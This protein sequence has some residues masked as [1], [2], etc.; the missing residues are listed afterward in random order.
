LAAFHRA[1]H[2]RYSLGPPAL[3]KEKL[4][5]LHRYPTYVVRCQGCGAWYRN[6]ALTALGARRG[7]EADPYGPG[8]LELLRRRYRRQY[9]GAVG[10]LRRW[11]PKG[12]RVLE[13]GSYAAAFLEAGRAAGWEVEGVDVGRDVVRYARDL[14]LTVHL[15]DVRDLDLP[16]EDYDAVFVWHC[17]EQVPEHY[18]FLLRLRDLLRPGGLLVLRTPNAVYYGAALGRVRD[19]P[20]AERRRL[21]EHLAFNGLLPFPFARAYPPEGL[22]LL[23]TACGFVDPRSTGSASGAGT[24]PTYRPWARV[25][26][27]LLDRWAARRL[28]A[29]VPQG[30]A[31]PWL[32]VTARRG[33][34]EPA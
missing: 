9:R 30:P 21:A 7:Y 2:A 10:R 13:V 3:W 20:A 25:R 23:L 27:A 33:R 18:G 34:R 29:A 1:F 17:F 24:D 6:P 8:V 22:R 26:G 28:R 11:V 15:G 32:E 16:L 14:G 31:A 4:H 19:G 12:A 5:F